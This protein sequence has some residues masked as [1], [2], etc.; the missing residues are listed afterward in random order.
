MTHYK[1]NK[2]KPQCVRTYLCLQVGHSLPAPDKIEAVDARH[3]VR[4]PGE[5][6]VLSA[7]HRLDPEVAGDV[8]DCVGVLAHGHLWLAVR[9]LAAAVPGD[10]DVPLGRVRERLSKNWGTLGQ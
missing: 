9:V 8:A 10:Q 3:H 5:P 4:L 6:T 1:A 2:A 7:L